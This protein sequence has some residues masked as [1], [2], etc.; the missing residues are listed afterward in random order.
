MPDLEYLVRRYIND[1][2][3]DA[4]NEFIRSSNLGAEKRDRSVRGFFFEWLGNSRHLWLWDYKSIKIELE[5]IGFI[6]IRRAMFNDSQYGYF[7]DVEELDRW[8]NCLGVE[9]VK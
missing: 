8:E 9:C 3:V 4:A 7:K 2:T 1:K 5:A 6:N